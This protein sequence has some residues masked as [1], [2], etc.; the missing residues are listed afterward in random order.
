M[1][2]ATTV[3]TW[4]QSALL[5]FVQL[6][7]ERA[8]QVVRQ[9]CSFAEKQ[10]PPPALPV[11]VPSGRALR[12]RTGGGARIRGEEQPARFARVASAT[13]QIR[14]KCNSEGWEQWHRGSREPRRA[15]P[16]AVA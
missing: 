13:A 4:Q 10:E 8:S 6:S 11:V 12:S 16:A 14:P 15:P 1:R 3:P 7:S 9:D 2:S 5:R